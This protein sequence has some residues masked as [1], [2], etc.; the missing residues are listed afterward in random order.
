MSDSQVSVGAA[1]GYAWSLWRTHCREIWGVLALNALAWTVMCAGLFSQNWEVI[2]AGLLGLL[3]TKYATYGAVIRLAYGGEHTDDPDFRLGGLGLQWRRMELRMFGADM[4]LGVFLLILATLLAIAIFAPV[5]AMVMSRG[6][7]PANLTWP[8]LQQM[9]GANG[10]TAVTV[11][12]LVLRMVLAFVLIR[13]SLYLPAT[14]VG[15]RIAIFRTWQLTRG[16]FWRI[17]ASTAVIALPTLLFMSIGVGAG[18][19]LDGKPTPLEPGETFLYSLIC[20]G[21]AGAAAMPL[22]AGVQAYFYRHLKTAK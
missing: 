12:E 21:W 10:M 15:G 19:S 1:L 3:V 16:Q 2:A 7:P 13:L 8:Q 20:G 5:F 11:G 18:L 9:I 14:A 6:A 17:F 22:A 4:L